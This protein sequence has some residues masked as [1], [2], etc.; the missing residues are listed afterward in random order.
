MKA[1]IY[2][3]GKM[4]RSYF[5]NED[6]L[7]KGILQRGIEIVGFADQN[8][9][10]LG[11]M[12]IYH[13]KS[14]TVQC[15]D[16]FPKESI[17]R[18]A[19][20]T[21]LYFHEIQMKLI[22]KGYKEEQIILLED[23][24]TDYFNQTIHLDK[25]GGKIG[26]EV[27]GPSK[28][29]SNIYETCLSCDNVCFSSKTVWMQN[30]TGCFTYGDRKLGK[31]WIDEASD[32]R[33]IPDRSYDFLLSSNNLEHIANPLKALREFNRVVRPGGI[34]LVL[35]PMKEKMFD[36]NREYTLFEHILEDYE[37]NMG[38]EDLSHLPE[39]IEK[40]DY[41]MD[42]ACGG[43]EKFIQRAQKNVE[44]RCLHHH[45]FEENCL[46][47]SFEFSGLKVLDFNTLMDNWLIMGK[48]LNMF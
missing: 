2:G 36:H 48:K 5:S 25:F 30:E 22:E 42:I 9:E 43:K 35:V 28:L 32:M 26:I 44:N 19:V 40:H 18:I 47:K 37:R 31:M 15:I 33:L 10:L 27:G 4:Y 29:F 7:E 46:R 6:F 23:I 13:K 41:D 20:T 34:V 8:I 1:V 17:D 38:E 3:I 16:N 11:K 24:F 39:I 14:F 12:V 45:V 21:K